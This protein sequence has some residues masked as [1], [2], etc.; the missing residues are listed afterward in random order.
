MGHCPLPT[1]SPPQPVLL[2]SM[3][4]P[5]SQRSQLHPLAQGGEFSKEEQRQALMAALLLPLREVEVPMK[6]K[7]KKT[8]PLSNHVVMAGIKWRTKDAQ[9]VQ[10]TRD[11]EQVRRALQAA[12]EGLEPSARKVEGKAGRIFDPASVT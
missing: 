10:L 9:A 12:D 11:E 1:L 8:E 5:F 7:G 2:P 4:V 3:S 6:G